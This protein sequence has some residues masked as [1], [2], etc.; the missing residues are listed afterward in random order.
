[1]PPRLYSDQ[2]ILENLRET[3]RAHGYEGASLS[4]ISAATGLGK[5]SLYHHFPGGKDAMVQAVLATIRDFFEQAVFTPLCSSA[6]PKVR[7]QRMAQKLDEYYDNGRK[8]CL[9][10][11]LAL[12]AERSLF[13]DAVRGYFERW[14]EVMTEVLRDAGLSREISARRAREGVARIHGAITLA[15][16]L[17]DP[18][19]FRLILEEMPDSL[20]LGGDRQ[21]IWTPG[22][23]GR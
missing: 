1:M 9:P 13:G 15:R 11:L 2:Q 23:L 20:L 21:N 4:R 12:G 3:F 7:M 14:I 5:A 16:G 19:V 10:Q 6:P 22:K 18:A 17:D 8:N